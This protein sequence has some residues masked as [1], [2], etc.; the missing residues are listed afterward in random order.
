M[1]WLTFWVSFFIRYRSFFSILNLR[2]RCIRRGQRIQSC[3]KLANL[4]IVGPRWILKWWVI[5]MAVKYLVNM[6]WN[7]SR[8]SK[9]IEWSLFLIKT[10]YFSSYIMS[11]TKFCVDVSVLGPRET[12][13]KNCTK[14]HKLNLKK[15]WI[16]FSW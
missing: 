12:N 6:I 3:L 9:S 1:S 2:R 13:Y 5:Q 16:F 11:L 15:N 7:C 10:K 14:G 8:R 4:I